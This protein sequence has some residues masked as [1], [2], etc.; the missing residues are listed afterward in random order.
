MEPFNS[1]SSDFNN[2]NKPF[3]SESVTE[4]IRDI[5]NVLMQAVR[6]EIKLARLEFLNAFVDVRKSAITFAIGT[7]AAILGI[8]PLM[9]FLVIGLGAL[10]GNYWLSALIWTV[11]F[12]G[13]GGAVAYLSM[14]RMKVDNLALPHSRH[15]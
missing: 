12:M 8:L 5:R 1:S 3:G 2:S 7:S 15:V 4:I 10:I 6:S 9:A 11:V 13:V 14:K